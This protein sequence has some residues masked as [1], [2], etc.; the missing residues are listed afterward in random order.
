MQIS[1][2]G[3]EVT[4]TVPLSLSLNTLLFSFAIIFVVMSY[5]DNY[6]DDSAQT[7][8]YA[9]QHQGPNIHSSVQRYREEA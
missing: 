8:V 9:M 6:V 1:F 5:Y 4:L 7:D 2:Y 3:L